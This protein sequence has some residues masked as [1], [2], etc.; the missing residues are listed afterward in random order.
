M[1]RRGLEEREEGVNRRTFLR[2]A[3][4]AGTAG[5]VGAATYG[6][7]AS[8]L[9]RPGTFEGL[10]T[11]L[12]LKPQGAPVQ[13]FEA[14]G[15]LGTEARLSHFEPGRGASVL[16]KA[17]FNNEGQLVGGLP[18]LLIQ[19]P[20]EELQFPS[21]L[22]RDDFVVQ[23][24]Y[25]IFNLCTHAGCRPGWQLVAQSAFRNDLGRENVYCPCHFSQY[26]PRIIERYQH[27]PPPESSGARY[28]GVSKDAAGP[29]DRGMP[30]IP[31]EVAGDTLVGLVR[32]PDWYK[33]LDFT[34]VD[35]E[36]TGEDV[37]V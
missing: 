31:L 16:W 22:P 7:V 26:N 33:Y 25:A 11:F 3:L 14:E 1:K 21:G 6:T 18:G 15:R 35:L 32:N 12:Y 9:T 34:Q 30:L 27:P 2:G 10:E 13:W 19:W 5:L 29:A 36:P 4:A 17:I 28:I 20:E 23:G 8:L 37:V 24:L